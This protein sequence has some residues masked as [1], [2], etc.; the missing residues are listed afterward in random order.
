[1]S[2]GARGETLAA[3]TKLNRT[4]AL[5]AAAALVPAALAGAQDPGSPPAA[6][7]APLKATLSVPASVTKAQL[8]KG[9]TATVGCDRACNARLSL[10]G[11]TGIVTQKSGDVAAG[12]K[13]KIK[14]KAA[15]AL[16]G[17]IKKGST[18]TLSLQARADDGGVA[19]VSKKVKI[20]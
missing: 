6:D 20:K 9:V 17:P 7:A 13:K 12:A 1:M 14:L 8:K 16:L 15:A 3:M 19:Q 4:I 10:A 5:A 11:P 2:G 18:Y